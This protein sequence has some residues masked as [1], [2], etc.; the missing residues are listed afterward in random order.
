MELKINYK[1]ENEELKLKKINHGDWIDLPVYEIIANEQGCTELEYQAGDVVHI[2]YGFAVQLPEGYEM[3][4]APR[5]STFQKY[6]L[7]MT[8]SIGIVDCSYCGA[9]DIVQ[10]K[11]VAMKDGK[12]E[13]GMRVAQFRI[14]ANQPAFDFIEV[15]E[16]QMGKD[17]GGYG[18]TGV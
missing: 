18:S 15:D 16:T 17:R 5:S 2:S 10:S 14:Q 4:I 11:F 13:K 3:I 12:I 7:V 1:H 6:G 8:N 9:N